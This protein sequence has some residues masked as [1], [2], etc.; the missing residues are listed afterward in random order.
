MRS[1]GVSVRWR[2]TSHC[3]RTSLRSSCRCWRAL[4]LRRR[5]GARAG[6]GGPF[7]AGRIPLAALLWRQAHRQRRAHAGRPDRC[8][9]WALRA[10]DRRRAGQG[11]HAGARLRNCCARR[12]LSAIVTAVVVD[13]H[14]P[15]ALLKADHA[16]SPTSTTSSSATAWTT[17]ARNARCPI[18]ARSE[19][20]EQPVDVIQFLLRPAAF[21][22]AAAAIPS[23]CCA[24]APA[25]RRS[26][27]SHCR[28]SRAASRPACGRADLRRPVG[29]AA[30]SASLLG[31]IVGG[32]CAARPARSSGRR[33]N[34]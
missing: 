6:A 1:P 21:G 8:R 31:E 4:R 19:L 12:A 34:R 11:R 2:A 9:A 13:K 29:P 23:K 30:G 10:S 27:L 20:L 18:S 33:S 7:A 26:V 25:R 32:R 16:A 22:G 14:L 28:R 15:E 24:P 17:P 3:A 5:S